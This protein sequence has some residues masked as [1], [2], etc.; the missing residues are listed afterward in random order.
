M[1]YDDTVTVKVESEEHPSL[2]DHY[3]EFVVLMTETGFQMKW[4][5]PGMKP[6][7]IFKII[8]KHVAEYKY[9]ILHGLWKAD[10]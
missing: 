6:E 10:V 9:C 5:N 2:D 3:I 7:A 8:D 4:L 1:T